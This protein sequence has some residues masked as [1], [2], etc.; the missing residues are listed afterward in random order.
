MSEAHL[1]LDQF[2]QIIERAGVGGE[3]V[4][5]GCEPDET[6]AALGE[7]LVDGSEIVGAKHRHHVLCGQLGR[8]AVE[9]VVD[10]ADTFGHQLLRRLRE[11]PGRGV[12]N[13]AAED[14]LSA[15]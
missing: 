7:R 6:D 12:I 15:Q 5:L 2:E 8:E 11:S 1:A 3:L 4:A 13:L 10:L 14:D 9:A